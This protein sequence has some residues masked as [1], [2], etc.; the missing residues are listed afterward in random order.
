MGVTGNIR[1]SRDSTSESNAGHDGT[2]HGKYVTVLGGLG[3][4]SEDMTMSPF[5]MWG[6]RR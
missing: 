4:V 2:T 5:E 6:V 1:R 3:T